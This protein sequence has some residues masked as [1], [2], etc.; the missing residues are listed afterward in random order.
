MKVTVI[1][2]GTMGNGSVA[3]PAPDGSRDHA[4]SR[5]ASALSGPRSYA[6]TATGS[7]HSS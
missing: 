2:A 6:A 1:G 7:S 5:Y 4:Q 3:Q